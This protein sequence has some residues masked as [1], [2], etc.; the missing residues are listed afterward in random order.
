CHSLGLYSCVECRPGFLIPLIVALHL[1]VEHLVLK[2][3]K[4]EPAFCVV[5]ARWRG[6]CAVVAQ[7]VTSFLLGPGS[8]EEFWS[9]FDSCRRF[10]TFVQVGIGRGKGFGAFFHLGPCVLVLQVGV[11]GNQSV[12]GALHRQRLNLFL[13]RGVLLLHRLQFRV[14]GWL[15]ESR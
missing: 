12:A 14:F 1:R 4:R 11:F 10:Q 9:Q 5:C 6:W 8:S 13:E 3:R 15:C 2:L 7:S